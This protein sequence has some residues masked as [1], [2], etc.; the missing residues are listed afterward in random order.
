MRGRPLGRLEVREERMTPWSERFSADM[1][2]PMAG[3]KQRPNG[4]GVT[5]IPAARSL[6]GTYVAASHPIVPVNVRPEVGTI[7]TRFLIRSKMP[8]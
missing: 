4:D 5:G 6:H 7:G 3:I 1:T 8:I 2:P